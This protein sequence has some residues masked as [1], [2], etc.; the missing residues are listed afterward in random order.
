MTQLGWLVG[1]QPGSPASSPGFQTQ[2]PLVFPG[3]GTPWVRACSRS[4]DDQEGT[5]QKDQLWGLPS[6]EAQAQ[7]PRMWAPY[8]RIRTLVCRGQALVGGKIPSKTEN[9]LS[10]CEV[11]TPRGVS[12]LLISLVKQ[13]LLGRLLAQFLRLQTKIPRFI[14]FRA[15]R[16]DLRIKCL[17]FIVLDCYKLF[18]QV[19]RIWAASP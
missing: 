2:E 1:R 3:L 7:L 5:S 12:L 4:G 9:V 10:F 8:A 18:I 19:P 13:L 15:R 6:H 16:V 14:S 17:T 11:Q